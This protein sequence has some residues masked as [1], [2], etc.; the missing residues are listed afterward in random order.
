MKTTAL[1]LGFVATFCDVSERLRI[2]NTELSSSKTDGSENQ[3]FNGSQK[4]EQNDFGLK[5]KD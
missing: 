5:D 2:V 4:S 3:I 1:T